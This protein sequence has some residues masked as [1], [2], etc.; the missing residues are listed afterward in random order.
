L[1][2]LVSITDKQL[3][4]LGDEELALIINKFQRAFNNRQARGKAYY[5]CGKT[6]HFAAECPKKKSSREEDDHSRR[7][8][9]CE[10][11]HKHKGGH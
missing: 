1:S 6:G 7:G 2:S 4:V 11:R 8:E 10:H 9:Y 3:E 5:N